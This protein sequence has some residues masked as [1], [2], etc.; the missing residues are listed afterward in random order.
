MSESACARNCC[1]VAKKALWKGMAKFPPFFSFF[2][3]LFVLKELSTY[4]N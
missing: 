4:E 2:F 1:F 3:F